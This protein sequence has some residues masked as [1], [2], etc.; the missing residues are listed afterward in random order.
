V[1]ALSAF[2]GE[3]SV[4]ET[5]K[6][7]TATEKDLQGKMRT[8][9]VR[10]RRLRSSHERQPITLPP[11]SSEEIIVERHKALNWLIRYMGENWDDIRTDT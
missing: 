2:G 10:T 6:Y 5:Q 1:I 11:N 8:L 7:P 9:T 4:S 3:H